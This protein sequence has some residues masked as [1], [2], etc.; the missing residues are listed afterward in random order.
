MSTFKESFA[1]RTQDVYRP[2]RALSQL[3][4]DEAS[5]RCLPARNS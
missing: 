1:V 4:I 2:L 3:H 5:V